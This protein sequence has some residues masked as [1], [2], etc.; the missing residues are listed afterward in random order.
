MSKAKGDVSTY[1]LSIKY[2]KV[3][4]KQQATWKQIKDINLFEKKTSI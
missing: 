3:E 4:E 2:N 1:Q